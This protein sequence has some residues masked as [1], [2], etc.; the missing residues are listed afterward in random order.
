MICGKIIFKDRAT[1]I[2]AMKGSN[3][4]YR[5][6][7][8][9]NLKVVYFCQDCGGWHTSSG[10]SPGT[11]RKRKLVEQFARQERAIKPKRMKH[12]FYKVN[13]PNKFKIK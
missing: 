13:S 2:A 9:K 3:N 7:K 5:K 8:R 10:K 12:E 6:S 4:D 11:V 1:A